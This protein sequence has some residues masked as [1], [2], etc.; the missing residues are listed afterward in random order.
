[1]AVRASRVRRRPSVARR[2]PVAPAVSGYSRGRAGATLALLLLLFGMAWL[3]DGSLTVEFLAGAGVPD[4]Y[5]WSVHV[6]LSVLQVASIV[7]APFLAGLPVGV[8]RGVFT[9]S[10]LAGVLNVFASA[11]TIYFWPVFFAIPD[12][13]GTLPAT[14]LGELLAF[15]PEPMCVWL[16]I[17][18]YNVVRSK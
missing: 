15:A 18:L 11:Y 4:L 6:M 5:G 10:L 3:F 16:F 14:A 13:W 2:S 1:M 9:V 7:A 17:G 8:R 12:K